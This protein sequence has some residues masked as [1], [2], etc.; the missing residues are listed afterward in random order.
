VA[1]CN[2]SRSKALCQSRRGPLGHTT[3][4]KMC[5]AAS[6]LIQICL[7]CAHDWPSVHRNARS[8]PAGPNS[9]GFA[10]LV[11][12][13]PA[14]RPSAHTSAHRTTVRDHGLGILQFDST[15]AS[16]PGLACDHDLAV[17]CSV[18]RPSESTFISQLAVLAILLE[19][20]RRRSLGGR[21]RACRKRID[22]DR[23]RAR[24]E[25]CLRVRWPADAHA[26]RA[27]A[28]AG[29]REPTACKGPRLWTPRKLAP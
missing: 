26:T 24:L 15:G 18:V 19:S 5:R 27:R 1:R 25:G 3:F 12:R 28:G 6:K 14:L 20:G 8:G 17:L 23:S 9:D 7:E 29:I 22:L 2:S 10:A 11:E 21:P 13:A 4:I 16:R